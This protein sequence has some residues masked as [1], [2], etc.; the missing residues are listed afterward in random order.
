MPRQFQL[1]VVIPRFAVRT[2]TLLRTLI[3][4][5]STR[6]LHVSFNEEALVA[7]VA[8]TWNLPPMLRVRE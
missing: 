5:N 4:L 2:T 3:G 6:V 7:D 1:P 8:P